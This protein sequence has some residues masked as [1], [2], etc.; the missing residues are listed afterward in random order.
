MNVFDL[1]F[2][3]DPFMTSRRPS[4]YVISDSEMKAYKHKQAAAEIIELK[5]LVDYHKTQA[6]RLED[7]ISQLEKDYPQLTASD[8]QDT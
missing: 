1:S 4:V 7:N 8:A 5:R 2:P 6:S 3:F